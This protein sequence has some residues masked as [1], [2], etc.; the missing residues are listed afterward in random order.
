MTELKD[1]KNCIAA[2][3]FPR[4][5][6][7]SLITFRSGYL[8]TNDFSVC[9]VLIVHLLHLKF[10]SLSLNESAPGTRVQPTP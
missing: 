8:P 5:K 6:Y 4:L 10:I 7:F 1:D 3:H 2:S 9:T